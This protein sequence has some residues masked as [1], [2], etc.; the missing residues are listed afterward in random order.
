MIEIEVNSV[1]KWWNNEIRLSL[2]APSET[3]IEGHCEI[4]GGFCYPGDWQTPI[5]N[6]DIK[7]TYYA[8][9]AQQ[10]ADLLA[11]RLGKTT[12]QVI[13]A[14][15]GTCEDIK[16]YFETK[17]AEEKAAALAAYNAM[18]ANPPAPPEEPVV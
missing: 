5:T 15:G 13:D 2:L 10:F 6:G 11:V 4:K 17:E 8:G 9:Y 16:L 14:I 3:G 1:V 18:L 7:P 12:T